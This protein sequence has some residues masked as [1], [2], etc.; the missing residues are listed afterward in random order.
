MNKE[1]YSVGRDF[2]QKKEKAK[3]TWT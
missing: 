1:N 3:E 2:A